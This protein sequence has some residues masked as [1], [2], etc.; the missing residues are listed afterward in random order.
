[1]SLKRIM[2]LGVFGLAT[3]SLAL[4]GC[5]DNAS[6]P[7]GTLSSAAVEQDI[8]D[9]AVSADF[10]LLVAAVQ[11]AGLESTLR[12]PNGPWTVL[13]PTDIAFG[14]LPNF[15]LNFLLEDGNNDLLADLLLYH[16]VAG[17]VP[18]SVVRTL[19]SAPTVL[20]Q[21]I[22]IREKR[23][24][25]LFVNRSEVILADVGASNG[26]IHVV[27]RVLIP[28]GFVLRVIIRFFFGNNSAADGTL[29]LANTNNP[30]L[31]Q[32]KNMLT[33][34]ERVELENIMNAQ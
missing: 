23:N 18:E 32:L 7:T 26:V 15:L 19:D 12:E 34:E 25:R 29:G 5:S 1:M 3:M 21:D 16:V 2:R 13:A 22:Q 27:D 33:M 8:V 17:E 4:V 30:D 10:N 20:G 6:T 9:V 11:Q 14:K 31:E 28:R 24:G